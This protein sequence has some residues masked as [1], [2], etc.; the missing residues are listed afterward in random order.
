[1]NKIVGLLILMWSVGAF[2][3]VP[4]HEDRNDAEYNMEFAVAINGYDPVSYFSEEGPVKGSEAISF[5]YGNVEYHFA[6][7]DNLQTFKGNPLKY[8]PTYGGYCAWAMSQGSKI[9]VKP[10]IY[11][12]SGNRLHLFFSKSAKKNFDA[13]VPRYEVDADFVWMN[14]SGEAPRL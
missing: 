3:D 7:E 13:D 2:A 12:I 4:V 5:T 8:E 6:S 9:G 1:V 10:L 14:F 11:T